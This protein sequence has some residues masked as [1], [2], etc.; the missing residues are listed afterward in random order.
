MNPNDLLNDDGEVVLTTTA[1][2]VDIGAFR[3]ALNSAAAIADTDDDG[4][5]VE[6]N[7]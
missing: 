3:D 5:P 1:R 4:A 6:P 2:T 7:E